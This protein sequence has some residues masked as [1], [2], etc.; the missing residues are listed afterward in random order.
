MLVA[1]L[2]RHRILRDIVYR[3]GRARAIDLVRKFDSWLGRDDRILDIGSGTCNICE[4]LTG[5]GFDVTPL[6]IQ[7]L[8][9]VDGIRAHLYD[10][11]VMPFADD[12]FETALVLT[13]LH[14]TRDPEA[15][16]R[17]ARRVAKR[18]VV[19]EDV[20]TDWLHRHL[21]YFF[22][23]LL[24]LEFAGHPHSNRSDA[25]WRRTF[26]R[27]GFRLVEAR[28]GRSL[29]VFVHATYCLERRSGERD[30]TGA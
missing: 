20:Y 4:I 1:F 19:M 12:G 27:L 24:N 15:V 3:A 6:D 21:T 7:D 10:G 16:L 11:S 29:V 23:S 17:E 28:L 13:V 30:E 9:F 25:E 14:H 5:R 8:S 26:E 2:Q 22:D 18:V